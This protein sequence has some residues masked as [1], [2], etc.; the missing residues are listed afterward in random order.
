M[1]VIVLMVFSII[2]PFLGLFI[3]TDIVGRCTDWSDSFKEIIHYIF[4]YAFGGI[5]FF[6]LVLIIA[7]F[8]DLM[9]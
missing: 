2:Y 5:Y 7:K 8:G 4:G 1:E 3:T 6:I 9:K